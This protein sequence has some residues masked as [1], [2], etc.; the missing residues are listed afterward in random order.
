MRKKSLRVKTFVVR[1]RLKNKQIAILM[2]HFI[3]R[4]LLEPLESGYCQKDQ[5]WC[6]ITFLHEN[7]IFIKTFAMGIINKLESR[8]SPAMITYFV[9][10][11]FLVWKFC[12]KTQ[13][14]VWGESPETIRNLCLCTKFPHQEIRWNYDILRIG[15]VCTNHGTV[16]NC[17]ISRTEISFLIC[18]KLTVQF[19][20]PCCQT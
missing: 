17:A 4:L 10:D 18:S 15:L 11:H 19:Q 5:I 13:F 3:I 12:G 6:K 16:P 14:L 1:K 20:K 2:H 8:D 7:V 9:T